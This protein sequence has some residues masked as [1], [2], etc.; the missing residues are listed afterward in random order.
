M[1][2]LPIVRT[3]FKN[4]SDVL[5]IPDLTFLSALA[6]LHNNR[7]LWIAPWAQTRRAVNVKLMLLVA[8]WTSE[9][10]VHYVSVINCCECNTFD[11]FPR[12]SA[13][14][15]CKHNDLTTIYND[16]TCR[17]VLWRHSRSVEQTSSCCGELVM[18]IKSFKCFSVLVILQLCPLESC[19]NELDLNL[20]FWRQLRTPIRRHQ[21]V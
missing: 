16:A 14:R 8:G 1:L 13:D 9:K 7:F 15:L 4:L 18:T 3:F 12:L 17:S 2:T 19:I 11:C 5:I 10:R 6:T 20:P 21:C